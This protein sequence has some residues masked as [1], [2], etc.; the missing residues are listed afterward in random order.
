M[1]TLAFR[2]GATLL[3]S[4][5]IGFALL[6][7][8]NHWAFREH[9]PERFHQS[10]MRFIADEAEDI[11]ADQGTPGMLRFF[12]ELKTYFPGEFGWYDPQGHDLLGGPDRPELALPNLPAPDQP[13]E[14]VAIEKGKGRDRFPEGKSFSRMGN[15][16]HGRGDRSIDR[17]PSPPVRMENGLMAFLIP[18]ETGKFR[19]VQFIPAPPPLH[20]PYGPAL[21]LAG[22]LAMLGFVISRQIA[23]PIRALKQSVESFGQG[24]LSHR[25]PIDRS[26]EIGDLS[27]TFNRMADQIAGIVERERGLV[28]SVAHE[29]RG[30][31]TRMKLLLERLREERDSARTLNRLDSEIATLSRIPDTLLHLARIET[32]HFEANPEPTEIG[33]FLRK[34]RDRFEP[35]A[36][37][38]D[39]QVETEAG[40]VENRS[41]EIDTALLERALEN[42][43]EN[44]MRHSPPGS[45]VHVQARYDDDRIVLSVRD[46]GPGVPAE[47]LDA[48]FQPFFRSDRSRNRGTGGV[49]LGLAIARASVAAMGGNIQAS[50]AEPGLCVTMRFPAQASAATTPSA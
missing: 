2:L 35:L 27:R 26:D 16:R 22:V 1:N 6:V 45:T 28:R 7:W 47:D 29:V 39:V 21:A 46:H 48:I 34:M 44:A 15:R 25:S 24:D 36:D 33:L 4:L 14:K 37:K 19:L 18:S 10:T 30:P 49:G 31:L 8:W 11:W 42:I 43:L 50:I 17:P 38:M 3:A 41:F 12:E 13:L 9:G 20:L 23:Q 5:A 32:G 40:D